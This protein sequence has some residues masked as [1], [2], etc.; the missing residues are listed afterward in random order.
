[1]R[2]THRT[3][4]ELKKTG[5]MVKHVNNPGFLFR[6]GFKRNHKKIITIDESISYLGGINFS[7]HNFEWH[8]MMI[9]IESRDIA[10]RLERDFISTWN[11]E[12]RF[13][14]AKIDDVVFHSLNGKN[15]AVSFLPIFD[16]ISNAKK[17]IM[18]ESPYL[19]FPFYKWLGDARRRGV[20]VTLITPMEN[21]WPF[22]SNYTKRSCKKYDIELK[23]LKVNMSHLKAMLIDDEILVMGSSNFDW[24]SYRFLDEIIAVIRDKELISEFKERVLS[25]DIRNS[26]SY[27]PLTS[28]STSENVHNGTTV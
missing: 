17:S 13:W 7:E 21:N 4:K 25:P 11:D 2:E 14:T 3:I 10:I 26:I 1:M 23:L 18:I 24:F 6:S 5:V 28:N 12:R 8:D 15:N 20:G 16:L 9:R 27:N 19:S 22:F